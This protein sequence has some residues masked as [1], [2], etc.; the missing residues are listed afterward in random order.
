MN[1]GKRSMVRALVVDDDPDTVEVFSE[2]LKLKGI[3]VVA[4]GHDGKEAVELYQEFKPDII[5]LDMKMPEYD[6][7]Y[8]IQHIR[9]EDPD[10]KI[11]IVTGYHDYK[12][13][14]NDVSAIFYKPYEIDE[15]MSAIQKILKIEN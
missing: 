15:I 3:D 13:D 10:A 2:Y 14:E 7:M 8:A 9:K 6:G 5:I 1:I 11:I 12:I 4:T